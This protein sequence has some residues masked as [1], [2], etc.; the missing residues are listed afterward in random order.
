[1]K[2]GHD[3]PGGEQGGKGGGQRDGVGAVDDGPVRSK[4]NGRQR[5]ET[6]GGES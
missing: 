4:G 3:R 2:V 1:M 5:V 6:L